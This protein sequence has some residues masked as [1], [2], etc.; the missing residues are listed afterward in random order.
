MQAMTPPAVAKE[1]DRSQS[2]ADAIEICD[3]T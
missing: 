2:A 1:L 3:D